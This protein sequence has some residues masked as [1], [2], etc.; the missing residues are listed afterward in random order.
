MLSPTGALVPKRKLFA[1]YL[2][3]YLLQ[4]LIQYRTYF[5][6]ISEIFARTRTEQVRPNSGSGSDKD[7]SSG[8]P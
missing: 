2:L 5:W 4:Y 8:E 1:I 7:P 3:Q 6:W